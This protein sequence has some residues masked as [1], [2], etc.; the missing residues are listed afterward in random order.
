[1]RDDPNVNHTPEQQPQTGLTQAQAEAR[2][3]AEGYNELSSARPRPL[4]A[5]AWDVV[6]EP[7]FL[8][9]MTCGII[10]LLIGSLQDAII[11]IGSVFVIV[12][13]SFLQERKSERTLEALR[14]LTSPRALVLRDGE[15]HRIAGREVV[16]EDLIYLAEGDRVPADAIVVEAQNLSADESLLT[17]ESVP[18]R[19][20]AAA[21]EKETSLQPKPGGDNLPYLFSGTLIVQGKGWARVTA[22][23]EQTALGHIGQALA[24]EKDEPSRVQT[25]TRQAVKAIA[26]GSITLVCFL[27]IWYGLTR[28]DWLNG[29]LAGLTLAMG[30]MPAEFPLILVIFLGLGAWRISK[31]QVLTRRIPAIEMLGAATVLCVD[32]TGTLTQNRMQV[33][34]VMAQG[35]IYRFDAPDAH[36]PDHYPETFH[37]VLE[38]AM[39]S[40]QRD[41]FDPMEKAIQETGHTVLAGTEHIHDSWTLIE[42]Y[43]LS[44]ELLAMSRVW[45]SPD[46]QQY[47]IAAK[48]APEAIIDLCHLDDETAGVIA[49]QVNTLAAQGL[50]ILAVA[51]AQF[52]ITDLPSNQ[53]DFTFEYLGLIALA[54]PLRPTVPAAVREC[55]DAGIRVIMITGDYPTTA[56]RIANDAGLDAK[57]R[58]TTCTELENMSD[59]GFLENIRHANVFCR[60]TPDQKLL[61]VNALKANGEIVAMTGDGVN[62]APALKAAHIGIAMGERGTDVARESASLVLLDD[63][64][65]SIVTAIRLGRRIFDNLRKAVVFIIAAHIP[66]AGMSLFPVM[67]GWPLLLLPIHIVFFELMMDPTCSLVFEGEAEEPNVMKRPPR[68]PDDRIFGAAILWLGLKQGVALLIWVLFVYWVTMTIG[69]TADEARALTFTAMI[70][71][72]IWLIFANRSWTRPIRT[73]LFEPNRA[74]GWVLGITTAVLGL[75]L[76]VPAIRT[77]FHFGAVSPAHVALTIAATLSATALL[78][79]LRFFRY[80]G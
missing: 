20:H 26:I 69:F 27:I 34:Q 3:K 39:L 50:R 6:T 61:L 58:I 65:S 45:Q 32:K 46:R 28:G 59:D 35:E 53:H 24:S 79:C 38:F 8:L 48:G 30:I 72:D 15:P 7:M 60:A 18:V 70:A 22:I 63:D 16:R 40:S 55:L 13:M 73:I 36:N 57:G 19:K 23:G 2:L 5:I 33:S 56:L 37:E 44:R 25:E 14:D 10:Y 43:P 47:I 78:S 52:Q 74:L 67:L 68:P 4:F 42:E 75:G 1:M 76:F 77:L 54:D 66:I 80:R 49:H 12:G 62:D 41:P 71:G 9:L 17:G 11:L 21:P 29:I 64:F 51:K 31:S